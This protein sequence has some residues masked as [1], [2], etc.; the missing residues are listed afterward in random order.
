MGEY[1]KNPKTGEEI[2]IGVLD[3]CFFS[4]D[5]LLRF[6]REGFKGFY[7]GEY[8]NV[9]HRTDSL[10]LMLK[11][12]NTLYGLP[13]GCA[14]DPEVH[15]LIVKGSDFKHHEV[16][17]QKKGNRGSVYNYMGLKCQQEGANEIYAVMIGERYDKE[18]N[19]RTI[20]QCDCCE[21]LF[22]ITKEEAERLKREHPYWSEWSKPNEGKGGASK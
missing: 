13:K 22:S 1:I 9:A 5:D 18:G 10:Q 15:V 12:P 19:T 14:F 4:R 6:Q 8:D 21:A 20:F 17:L 3:Q 11:N 7:A 2:K 16:I